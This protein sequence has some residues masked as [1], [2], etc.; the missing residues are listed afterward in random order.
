MKVLMV[1][2]HLPIPPDQG[3][4]RVTL[5][6][7]RDLT[8]VFDVSYLCM[9][10]RPEEARLLPELEGLGVSVRAPL[11]PN[12]RSAVH[13]AVYRVRNDAS[14]WWSGYPREY[15]YATPGVLSGA[16]RRWTSEE[17][18]DLVLL[19]H[20]RLARLASDVR[21]GRVVVLAHDAEFAKRRRQ[22]DVMGERSLSGWRLEREARREIET[23]G[24]CPTILT[25]TD[26]DRDQIR[27][28]LG[29]GYRGRIETLPIAVDAPDPLP[30]VTREAGLVGFLGSFKGDFNV[31]AVSFLLEEIWP[32]VRARQPDARLEIAGGDAPSAL[33]RAD[34]R[35]GVTFRGFV[36]DPI[37]FVRRT[38][39]FVVPLRF[40][41]GIRIR[42]VEAFTWGAAVVS[43]P[44]GVAGLD[45]E[46][47]R[48]YL[49]AEAGDRFADAIVRLL[50]DE[51][52]RNQLIAGGQ[53]LSR[54][55]YT[56]DSVRRRTL[57]LFEDLM[58]RDAA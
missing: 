57:S 51:A 19:E 6:L 5:G 26:S 28:E 52:L 3:A 43:T 42:L 2:P 29:T 20:W 7:L 53:A 33:T 25:L 14:A 30:E 46:P 27:A 9:L 18:F 47:D 31:D 1:K 21:S 35:D 15:F 41:S 58:Q 49:D 34:G 48:H 23:L 54:D 40:G 32:R 45:L 17:S 56:P 44:V 24:R 39:A 8:S 38:E 11:M 36:E 50:E 16:L 22:R 55:R 13:R 12:R 4:R 37:Q 10:E